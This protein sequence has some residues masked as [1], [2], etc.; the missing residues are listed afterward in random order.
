M[1]FVFTLKYFHNCY[2][3]MLLKFSYTHGFIYF[4]PIMHFLNDMCDTKYFQTSNLKLSFK[5]W[6]TL[7][8]FLIWINPFQWIRYSTY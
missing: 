4:K 2:N 3:T 6:Q 1:E 8:K 7:L 5:N